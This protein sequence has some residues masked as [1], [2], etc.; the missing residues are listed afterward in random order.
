MIL[1]VSMKNIGLKYLCLDAHS[2]GVFHVVW[3]D[4]CGMFS[5]SV[6]QHGRV[7]LHERGYSRC[8]G[9]LLRSKRA[10]PN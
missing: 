10:H 9:A 1:S 8:H 4:S 2:A 6:L 7:G 5:T 3:L